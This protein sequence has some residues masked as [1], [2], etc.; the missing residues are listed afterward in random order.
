MN[1]L[2]A[3]ARAMCVAG[4][5]DPDEMM[6]NDGPR[7]RYYVPSARA[8]LAA[9]FREMAVSE[10]VVDVGLLEYEGEYALSNPFLRTGME[11]A[12]TAMCAAHADELEK[13]KP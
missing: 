1:A 8:A 11:S 13:E 7:W 4:G 10:A 6:S 5:F 9:Y 12:A 3:A 2:E